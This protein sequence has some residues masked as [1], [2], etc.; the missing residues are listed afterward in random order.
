MKRKTKRNETKSIHRQKTKKYVEV[1]SNGGKEADYGIVGEMVKKQTRGKGMH[2]G[3]RGEGSGERGE[4][5]NGVEEE[6][7]E[8]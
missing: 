8:G 3:E 2:T 1:C 4:V 5:G 6:G 7:E